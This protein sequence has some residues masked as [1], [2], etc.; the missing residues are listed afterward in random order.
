VFYRLDPTVEG[1]RVFLGG[2]PTYTLVINDVDYSVYSETRC[3]DP[4][5]SDGYGEPIASSVV[6]PV[7][8]PEGGVS[9]NF[10]DYPS[11]SARISG[12]YELVTV[13]T[14][15][16]FPFTTTT[17]VSEGTF[18]ADRTGKSFFV[19][20]QNISLGGA[21]NDPSKW[22]SP[23][24]SPGEGSAC[25]ATGLY[26]RNGIIIN[27]QGTA[28]SPSY[29]ADGLYGAN[30]DMISSLD[31]NFSKHETVIKSIVLLQNVAG[32]GVL[33]DEISGKGTYSALNLPPS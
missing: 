12:T 18:S 25:G 33:G 21:S 27:N 26:S 4:S 2:G 7:V 23:M 19:I 30:I 24:G 17:T 16:E 3:P 29:F 28:A 22:L 8:L 20:T 10:F 5:A 11:F 9:Y 31:Y 15:C 14:L 32:L 1:G 13:T 6:G